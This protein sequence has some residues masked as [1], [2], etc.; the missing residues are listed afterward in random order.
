[1]GKSKSISVVLQAC[2]KYKDDMPKQIKELKRYVS[3]GRKSGDILM[4]GAAYC[5]LAM[6]Y[7]DEDDLRGMLLN[8]LKAVTILKDTGEYDLLV[9]A[10]HVLG[11]AYIDQG[12]NQMSLVCDETAYGIVKRH[13]LK[14]QLR[15]TALNNISV[16]YHAMDEPRKS[17]KYLNECL[18]LLKTDYSEEYTDYFMYSVNL[19]GCHKDVGELERADEIFDSIYG[20]LDKVGF[21]PLVCDYYIR[22]AIVSYLREDI[23]AGNGYIDTALSSFPKNIYPLPL[24]DDLCEVSR[25]IT[26]NKDRERSKKILDLMTVFAENNEGT[27]EQ[28]F[29]TR[30]IANYY[31]NFGEYELATEYFSKCEELNERQMRELRE[32]QMKLHNTT[33]SAE[34]EIR[35]LKR[36]MRENEDLVSRD[37]LSKLLNRSALLRVSSE[38]I[39]SAAKK[40]Q[41]VGVIFID[42]D[43]F[44]ECNDTYGHAK[45]DEIIRQ[46]ADVCRKRETKNV[47]FAR[48]GGDE[49]FGITRGLTDGEVCDIA[50]IICKDIRI[51]DIPNE[52]NPNGGRLTLSAGVINVTITDKT[53]TILEIANYADKALYYAKN[54]GRN[55]IYELVHSDGGTNDTG[56]SAYIKIDF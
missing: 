52:K 1:M 49:F 11:R 27:L 32:M 55:A 18:E 14:G 4:L 12:N 54:A 44:K 38:F 42:I 19:A 51:A 47:R 34:A 40:R 35:K 39:E 9:R 45:G 53:D 46:V 24:Y 50:R 7:S 13:R 22:R 6:A 36:K 10:Y 8:A 5:Y 3:E 23:K 29:A 33:R 21:K 2:E 25:F 41:K 28:L 37:P 26:N 56:S 30:M 16:S 17:I 48:Y 15:I 31:K 20:L 43:C